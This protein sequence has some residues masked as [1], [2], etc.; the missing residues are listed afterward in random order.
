M[1]GH[2]QRAPREGLATRRTFVGFN[3]T[4]FR[5]HLVGMEGMPR[6]VPT[7]SRVSGLN[8]FI[9]MRRSD[10]ACRR[11]RVLY[12]M[13]RVGEWPDRARNS[14]RADVEW[15]VTRRRSLFNSTRSAGFFFFFGSQYEYG[16][17][18][19]AARS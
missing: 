13:I 15:Q 10:S 16:S 5:G 19:R 2:V 8:M 14:W 3:L 12:N 9:A 18:G 7:T 4:F 11:P 6:R 17:A 1:T